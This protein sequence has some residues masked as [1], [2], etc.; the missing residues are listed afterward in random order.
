MRFAVEVMACQQ[1]SCRGARTYC[2]VTTE[3]GGGYTVAGA[4]C[5]GPYDVL[6]TIV[7]DIPAAE[8]LRAQTVQDAKDLASALKREERER[9]AAA[10]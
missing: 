6:D 10:R 4:K 2:L 8:M 9:K 3:G 1:R 5:G 7:F